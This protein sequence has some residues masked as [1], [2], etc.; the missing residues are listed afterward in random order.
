MLQH[1]ATCFQHAATYAAACCN[2][3]QHAATFHCNS[4]SVRDATTIGDTL[5]YYNMLL[6]YAATCC[7][8]LHHAATCCNMLQ[9]VATCCNMLQRTATTVAV[10]MMQLL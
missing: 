8:L 2:T 7:N 1:A 6:Q 3:L 9:Y 5:R 4:R 10:S